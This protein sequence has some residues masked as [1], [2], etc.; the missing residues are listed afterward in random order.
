MDSVNIPDARRVFEALLQG[1]QPRF[2]RDA[3]EYHRNS[4]FSKIAEVN[5]KIALLLNCKELYQK[6]TSDEFFLKDLP[7]AVNLLIP[8]DSNSKPLLGPLSNEET[9]FF[10]NIL[11]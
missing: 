3:I 6:L 7:Q 8:V 11:S 9:M 5:Y 4:R 2:Q 10:A 1:K